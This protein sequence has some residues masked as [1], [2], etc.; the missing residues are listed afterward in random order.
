MSAVGRERV[1]PGPSLG[2]WVAEAL[3]TLILVN[4]PVLALFWFVFFLSRL[5][6]VT[7]DEE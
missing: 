3:V 1:G 5:V 2:L 4:V 7:D 6:C